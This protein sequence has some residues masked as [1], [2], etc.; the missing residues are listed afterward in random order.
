MNRYSVALVPDKKCTL[1]AM[2]MM[3]GSAMIEKGIRP[4]IEL[5]RFESGFEND[6]IE[7]F[8]STAPRQELIT[9]K[10][11]SAAADRYDDVNRL[12]TVGL[13]CRRTIGLIKANYLFYSTIKP[14]FDVE[15]IYAPE[16]FQPQLLL[17]TELSPDEAREAFNMVTEMFTPFESVAE[18]ALLIRL[19]DMK[20]IC[21]HSLE[22]IGGNI[23][24]GRFTALRPEMSL[25]E[26]ERVLMSKLPL[27]SVRDGKEEY[28]SIS[29]RDIGVQLCFS[30]DS[31]R[32]S[33][34]RMVPPY[35]LPMLGL[36]RNAVSRDLGTPDRYSRPNDFYSDSW[37]YDNIISDAVLRLDFAAPPSGSCTAVCIC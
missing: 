4:Q 18:K 21:E 13:N 14:S 1:K 6:A 12:Y 10:F 28:D 23:P 7:V 25:R 17:G 9:V 36:D 24:L 22:A 5:I 30:T 26:T 35:P 3:C 15:N 34:I 19:D 11:S 8:E 37:F 2:G 33:Y 20:V 16:C 27:R 32:L 29:F 31:R